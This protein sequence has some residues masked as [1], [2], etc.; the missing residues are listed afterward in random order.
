MEEKELSEK[1]RKGDN[2][3]RKVLYEK[4]ANRLC[5]LCMRYIG[6]KDTALDVLHDGFIKIFLSFD[7]FTYRGEGSLL[8][9]TQRIIINEALQYLRHNK[10]FENDI[11]IDEAKDAYD[12]PAEND[13]DMI[14][15]KVLMQ[16]IADLPIGYR[17][18]FNLYTFE[19]KSHKEIGEILHIN[20]KSSSSQLF[21]AKKILAE[22]INNWNKLNR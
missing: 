17:T 1:C 22:R 12:E 14:P 20:E 13:V 16:F 18:V 5:G 3:A 4:Y 10:L 9:W 2:V 8:A 7:H 11:S 6:D 15:E 19:N 21:H